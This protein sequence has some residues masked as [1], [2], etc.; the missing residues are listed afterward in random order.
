M[1]VIGTFQKQGGRVDSQAS[2]E[3]MGDSAPRAM[4]HLVHAPWLLSLHF[5]FA[6]RGG[7]TKLMFPKEFCAVDKV[8][9]GAFKMEIPGSHPRDAGSV[10]AGVRSQLILIWVVVQGPHL[11]KFSCSESGGI[12]T[13]RH[14]LTQHVHSGGG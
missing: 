4:C 11:G 7:S 12:S 13:H 5:S 6:H 8:R 10:G 2:L 14:T 1:E 9:Q 3:R